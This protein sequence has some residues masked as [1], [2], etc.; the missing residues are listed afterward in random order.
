[1]QEAFLKKKKII[2]SGYHGWF[3]WYLATNLETSQNLNEHLIEGLS[4]KGVDPLLKKSIFPF[5]YDDY[6]DFLKTLKKS[7]DIGIVIVESARYDY[8]KKSFVN[9]I[10]QICK[11]KKLI[12]ICDEITSG[13][14]VTNSGAYKIIGFKPDIIVYGKGLGNGFAISAIVGKKKIMQ[15]SF[16]SFISSSNWSE[17]VG[18]VSAIKTLE[19]MQKKKNMETFK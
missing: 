11:K 17:R 15:N 14:R 13:F 9:K 5:K 19:Y 3:D 12:L 16:N 7:K 6:S 8:P 2:F 10:N 4:P 18:F 1:M